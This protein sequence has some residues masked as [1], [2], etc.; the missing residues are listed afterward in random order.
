MW[1]TRWRAACSSWEKCRRKVKRKPSKRSHL[2]RGDDGE[3]GE[4]SGG[5]ESGSSGMGVSPV[6]G[7]GP[8]GG[9][10]HTAGPL[11]WERGNAS[12]SCEVSYRR[13]SGLASDSAG[14]GSATQENPTTP[15]GKVPSPAGT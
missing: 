10:A 2:E 5:V 1:A 12:P 13:I 7:S 6:L 3:A 4:S 9:V 14:D 11:V 8:A 15:G